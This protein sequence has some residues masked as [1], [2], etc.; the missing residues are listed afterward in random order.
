MVDAVAKVLNVSDQNEIKQI[1]ITLAPLLVNAVTTGGDLEMMN[2]LASEGLDFGLVDYR[3][4]GPIH[5]AAIKGDIE[6]VKF[7]IEQ[8]VNLDFVD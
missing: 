3:G 8:R 2:S 7:L 1:N 5:I 6:I 4:R